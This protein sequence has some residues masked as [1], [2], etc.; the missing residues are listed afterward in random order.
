[1]R[2]FTR[3]LAAPA[4]VAALAGCAGPEP[5]DDWTATM[6]PD[7]PMI[8]PAE[9]NGA[10]FQP[11]TRVSLFADV[12]ARRVGDTLTIRLVEQTNASTSASTNTSRDS[13]T[14]ISNPTLSGEQF[15]RGSEGFPLF[16]NSLD[17]TNEFE[18]EGDSS[19][20]N[21]MQGNISVTVY[22]RLPNGNLVV[23]GEKWIKINRG[24]ELLRVAGIVRPADIG[25]DN[26]VP[27]FKVADAR[28]E[29]TARGAIG[30]ANRAGWLTRFFQS[31]VFPF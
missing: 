26:S 18:A 29:Y 6:P 15:T 10:I 1:M 4:V 20:S 17:S 23:R 27:S 7:P 12:K 9:T 14:G 28:L 25:E 30:D 13:S 8:E 21:S 2:S 19:Q 24:R 11:S 22:R 5:I 3:I 31:P 16:Q